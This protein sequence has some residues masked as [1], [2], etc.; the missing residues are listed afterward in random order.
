MHFL[1][2]AIG[3]AGDVHPFIAVAQALQSR[4]HDVAVMASPYFETRIE[5]AGVPFVPLGRIEDFERVVDRPELWRARGGARVLIDE[6]LDHLPEACATTAAHVEQETI[7]VGSTLSWGMRIVQESRGLPGATIHL[8]PPCLPSAIR[9]PVLPGIGDLAWLPVA[10]RRLL[11]RIGERC[12]LDPLIAPRLDR[13]RAEHGLAPVRHITT[14]WIHSPDLVIA[15]W[16]AWFA[17]PQTDWPPRTC[18]TDFPIHREKEMALPEPVAAFLEDGEP[19]IAITPGSA[20]AHGEAFFSRALVACR[21][22]GR[23]AVLIT[24]YPA[25]LPD[26]LPDWAHHVAYAPFS[27]L[28]PRVAALIHHG[29]IGTSAQALAAGKPQLVVPFAHDQ[30]DNAARLRR[31]GVADVVN[32]TR[33]GS[34]WTAALARLLSDRMVADAVGRVASRMREGPAAT[35]TIAQRLE[36]LGRERYGNGAPAH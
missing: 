12:V 22:L 11:L 32:A 30:F 10:L 35:D 15:A 3:S 25:Q 5:R 7:V 28:L 14:R 27:A 20:M 26:H 19:P 6:L 34:S 8:S 23:R 18:T 4:G 29:G 13:V 24:P 16:P 36:Q 21:A 31:L 1:L 2:S 17:A 33:S 9:S